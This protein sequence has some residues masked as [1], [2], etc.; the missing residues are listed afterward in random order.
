MIALTEPTLRNSFVNVSLRERKA[1]VVPADLADRDWDR[2]DYV[3][4]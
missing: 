2:L 3:G 4:W 1:I